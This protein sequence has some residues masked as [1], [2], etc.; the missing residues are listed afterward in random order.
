MLQT[1]DVLNDDF[2]DTTVSASLK[3]KP[4][5]LCIAFNFTHRTSFVSSNTHKPIEL[6]QLTK[7]ELMHRKVGWYI[8]G[9]GK[10]IY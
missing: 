4:K 9:T 1:V 3:H 7:L 10:I 8:T 6:D 2:C 5:V